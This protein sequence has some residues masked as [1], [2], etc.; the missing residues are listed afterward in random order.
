MMQNS[1]GL[2]PLLLCAPNHFP[3]DKGFVL[4]SLEN[5]NVYFTLNSLTENSLMHTTPLHRPNDVYQFKCSINTIYAAFHSDG[6]DE[7]KM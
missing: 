5:Q 2:L 7:P 4:V 6:L 3:S 1:N